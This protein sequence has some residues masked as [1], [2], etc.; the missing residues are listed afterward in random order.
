MPMLIPTILGAAGAGLNAVGQHN[1]AVGGEA[2]TERG[3]MQ[4]AADRKKAMDAINGVTTAEANLNPDARTAQARQ[5][6]LDGVRSG[7]PHIASSYATVPGANQRYTEAVQAAG[8][9]ADQSTEKR[10]NLMAM[11]R[12]LQRSRE[13]VRQKF[14]D[15]GTTVSGI[16]QD[17]GNDATAAGLDIQHAS[18]V[19]PA[20][21]IAGKFLSNMG[22]AY[23]YPGSAAID[24][25][26]GNM[27]LTGMSYLQRLPPNLSGLGDMIAPVNYG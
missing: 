16:N 8:N 3:L 25:N 2:A 12:G 9:E 27:D 23:K 1:A 18:E 22:S 5:D 11:L 20:Y 14:L 13:D 15:A 7:A 21:G 6:F 4:Q 24:P 17:A 10:A 26:P 19:N